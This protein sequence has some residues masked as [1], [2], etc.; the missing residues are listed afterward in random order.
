[1]RKRT[2]AESVTA[3]V[4]KAVWAAYGIKDPEA[5]GY[6]LDY[7]VPV[8]LGGALD[9]RNLWPL[10]KGPSPAAGAVKKAAIDK[11]LTQ[12]VCSNHAGIQAAQHALVREW[13]TALVALRLATP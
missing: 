5:A 6:V 13:P 4:S 2:V 12:A 11:A 3:A 10:P 1:M 7:L 8:S 9:Y